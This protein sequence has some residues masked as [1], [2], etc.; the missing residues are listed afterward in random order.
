VNNIIVNLH[1]Y[2]N[3]FTNLYIFNLIID[4]MI[5]EVELVK[6]ITFPILIQML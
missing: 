2:Y 1:N 5:L 3:N 4:K 6:W